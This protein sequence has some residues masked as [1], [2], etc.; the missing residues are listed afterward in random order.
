MQPE[1]YTG[2]CCKRIKIKKKFYS[3][4]TVSWRGEYNILE[5]CMAVPF[6]K[7]AAMLIR[8]MNAKILS[9]VFQ[10]VQAKTI[11]TVNVIYGLRQTKQTGLAPTKTHL[12]NTF[13][14]Q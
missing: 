3:V 10:G 7:V 12:V 8:M 1:L 2:F 6:V 4:H 5:C 11:S 9:F 14:G 13:L